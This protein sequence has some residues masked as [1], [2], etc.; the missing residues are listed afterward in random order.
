MF[1][2][3]AER[4]QKGNDGEKG[5]GSTTTTIR[6]RESVL[7]PNH[8]ALTEALDALFSSPSPRIPL[9]YL[10][11]PLSRSRSSSSSE[12]I[13]MVIT[14]EGR[15]IYGNSN[16]GSGK[17]KSSYHRVV[18]STNLDLQSRNTVAT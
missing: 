16:G 17:R 9:F 8:K 2:V 13:V 4:K 7:I 5:D 3:A 18:A 15:R 10:M 1:G 12:M 6:D 14:S 11:S